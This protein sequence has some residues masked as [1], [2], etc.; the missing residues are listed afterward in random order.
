VQSYRPQL[1]FLP[2]ALTHVD[3]CETHA[4][5]CHASNILGPTYVARALGEQDATLVFFS[6]EHVFADSAIPLVETNRPAPKSVYA[7]SKAA[8]EEAIRSLLPH[9]HL[10]LRT[11]WVFGPESQQK[12]FVY[13]TIRTL[14]RG[15]RLTVPSD[16]HGQPTYAPD[17]AHTALQL[18]EHGYRGTFH[19][20]GPD[21]LNRFDFARLIARTFG[22]DA[23]LVQGVPTAQ[24]GQPAPRPLFVPLART[25]LCAALKR[26]PIRSPTAALREMR[27]EAAPRVA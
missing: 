20:V 7:T 6:T 21:C 26:D 13:R 25:K 16:Q 4:E 15:E 17:L 22:L 1:V 10:I 9:R 5:E 12:N 27:S 11:S 2:A 3:Y 24:L 18:W 14:Q 8:A 23:S 19:V